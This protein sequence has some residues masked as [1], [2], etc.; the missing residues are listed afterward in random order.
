MK[1]NQEITDEIIF[2]KIK[3]KEL[4]PFFQFLLETGAEELNAMGLSHSFLKKFC[5]LNRLFFNIPRKV[6][7]KNTEFFFLERN[8]ETIAGFSVTYNKKKKEFLLGNV[9]TRPDLQGQGI[10]NILLKQI[11]SEHEISSIKLEV[12]SS[13]AIAIHLYEKYGF[14]RHS[15][16]QNYIWSVPLKSKPLPKEYIIR[17][18]SKDDLNKLERI[19]NEVPEMDDLKDVF[20]RSLNKKSKKLFRILFY[21]PAIILKN[22]EIVGFGYAV[23]SK[24]SPNTA[25]IIAKA[26]IPDAKEAYPG[27]ISFVTETIQKF[28]IEKFV[29]LR[30]YQ[31][32]LYFKEMEPFVGDP[33]QEGFIMRKENAEIIY[34]TINKKEKQDSDMI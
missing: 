19:I 10:G 3:T 24:I 34:P 21:L 16:T 2:R 14:T 11:I 13:N 26:V 17:E 30:N 22:N 5:V 27:L 28:G 6:M 29:W 1:I 31:T 12:N 25:D 23:W 8:E 33:F 9:F 32:E 18:A 4:Y 20:K 7:V 15:I